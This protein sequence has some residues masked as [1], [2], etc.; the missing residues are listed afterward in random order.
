MVYSPQI[1]KRRDMNK[2]FESGVIVSL[3]TCHSF[4]ERIIVIEKI[5]KHIDCFN[6]GPKSLSNHDEGKH[7]VNLIN[8][9]KSKVFTPLGSVAIK[10]NLKSDT[11]FYHFPNS[12]EDMLKARECAGDHKLFGVLLTPDKDDSKDTEDFIKL[13]FNLIKYQFDGVFCSANALALLG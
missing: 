5:S 1:K 8:K 4:E 6:L 13:I 12:D 7:L 2:M 11:I 10:M 9:N 3:D